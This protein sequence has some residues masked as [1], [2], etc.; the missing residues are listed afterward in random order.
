MDADVNCVKEY[1]PDPAHVDL[2]T[3]LAAA[4]A[5]A[6]T[7]APAQP[8]HAASS[9]G[10]GTT[11]FERKEA[12]YGSRFLDTRLLIDNVKLT[13]NGQEY[14][15]S[16]ATSG[17][18]AD[19][20]MERIMPMIHTNNDDKYETSHQHDANEDPPSG[21]GGASGGPGLKEFQK[22]LHAMK[23]R[24]NIYVIPFALNPEGENPSGHLDFSK[25][26]HS[27][28]T[29]NGN[30]IFSGGAATGEGAIGASVPTETFTATVWAVN[31]NWVQLKDGRGWITFA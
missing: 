16:L 3:R 9:Q 24:K 14:H 31:Y 26:S 7:T 11:G 4:H 13:I 5:S 8:T 29:I 30:G 18:D 1:V 12:G 17:L 2:N 23:G 22:H 25:V 15:P 27:K 20:L 21:G 6:A 10:E 28:L 19:Y